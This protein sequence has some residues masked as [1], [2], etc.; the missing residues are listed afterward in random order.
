MKIAVVGATGNIG[1]RLTRKLL[2]GGHQVRA[3]SR[4]GAGLDRVVKLGAEPFIGSFDEGTGDLASFFKDADAAFT[5]VK[6]DWSNLHG[7]YPAVAERLLA[8][9]QGS[10]V[11]LVVNL[12]SFGADVPEGT[13]HFVGF[14][15]LEQVL[16]RLAGPK[17]VHLRGGYFMEN[18]LAWTDAV[19]RHGR[20]TYYFRPD[21]KLP[22]IATR[23]IA[24]VAARDLQNP[25]A[26]PHTVRE[27]GSEDLDK[28]EMATV[29]AREIGRPVEYVAVPLDRED[30][31]KEF[32]RRFGTAEKLQ[33]DVDTHRAMNDGR[34]AFHTRRAP[35]PTSFAAFVHDTW[36]PAYEEALANRDSRPENFRS[37]L[38]GLG[39]A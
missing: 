33:Y 13:G 3:L 25:P 19:A 21:V 4:G 28:R 24:E 8:A 15:Q 11:K 18:L 14:H 2:E 38:A 16:N 32:V 26:A 23:D 35:L 37:W 29:I 30:I 12:S 6:T 22:L 34:V 27:V 5:M 9:L 36:R 17:L 39:S 7:H 1:A 10:P 31:G 20:M